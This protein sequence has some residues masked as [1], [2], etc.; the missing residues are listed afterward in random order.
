MCSAFCSE[1][2]QCKTTGTN[3]SELDM[4]T[5]SLSGGNWSYTNLR[6]CDFSG[7]KIN[8]VNFYGADLRNADFS[9]AVL[10]ECDFSDCILSGT[11]FRS[12]DIRENRFNNFDVSTT[13][14]SKARVD[15]AFAVVAANMLG[16]EVE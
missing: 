12:A 16:A 4:A 9:K 1:F 6:Y 2:T 7:K 8:G 3:F 5:V 14:L 13:N 11:S 15:I 10:R